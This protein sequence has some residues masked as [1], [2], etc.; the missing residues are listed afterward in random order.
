MILSRGLREDAQLTL[1]LA[2]LQKKVSKID[3]FTVSSQITIFTA[4]ATLQGKEV[5]E[6]MDVSFAE[7]Y[8]DLDGGF[9]PLVRTLNRNANARSELRVNRRTLSSPTFPYRPTGAATQLSL[10]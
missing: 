3:A 5:R 1:G 2:G 7:L 6:A 9:T 8:H 10:K 4:S